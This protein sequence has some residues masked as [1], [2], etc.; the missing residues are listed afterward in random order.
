MAF[1]EIPLSGVPETFSIALGPQSYRLRIGFANVDGG[2]W[3]FDLSD[4]AGNPILCGIPLVTGCDLLGPY[5]YLGIP[6]R[7][8]VTTDGDPDAVPTFD[9]LGTTSHLYFEPS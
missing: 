2:G 4:T 5:R 3:F 1:Y 8:W 6:G 7:L 9:D